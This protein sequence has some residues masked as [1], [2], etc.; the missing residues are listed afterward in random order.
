MIS[1]DEKEY[2][3]LI[4][5]EQKII[6]DSLENVSK[7]EHTDRRQS[8]LDSMYGIA[9]PKEEIIQNLKVKQSDSVFQRILQKKLSFNKQQNKKTVTPSNDMNQQQMNELYANEKINVP[10]KKK[11][12]EWYF[13]ERDMKQ[14]IKKMLLVTSQ[15]RFY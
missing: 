5:L 8:K 2:G 12:F 10:K 15:D 6:R 9:P 1:L 11:K 13:F 14:S 7:D 3:H 4:S